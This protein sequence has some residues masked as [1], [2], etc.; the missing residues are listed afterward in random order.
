MSL[1]FCSS[2]P[3]SNK[4]GAIVDVDTWVELKFRFFECKQNVY[5]PQSMNKSRKPH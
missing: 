3:L 1:Y 2:C 5:R 4:I